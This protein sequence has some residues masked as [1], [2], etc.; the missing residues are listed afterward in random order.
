M[1]GPAGIVPGK[2]SLLER[3]LFGNRRAVLLICALLTVVLGLSARGITLNAAFD[4][5]IPLRHPFIQNFLR[6]QGDLRAGGNSLKI[7]V[8]TTGSILDP[9]YLNTLRAINDD[10]FLM[11]GIDRPYMQSLW[12]PSVRWLAVTEQGFAGGP[13]MPDH[14]DGSAAATAGLRANIM[15]SGEVGQLV[16]PDFKSSMLLVPLL[17]RDATTGAMLDYG[18]LSRRLDAMRLKYSSATIGIHIVGF[19][20]VMGDLIG[21]LHQILW[22]FAL[23]VVIATAAVYWFTR[24]LR[25]TAVVVACSLVA[26]IWQIG[27]LPLLGF[28]FDPYSILVPFLIFAI[29]MSH[30][31]Q[32]MN[33]VMQDIGRGLPS[34]QAARMTFRRLFV[35]GLTAL[36]CDAVGFAVLLVI[37]IQAIHSLALIASLGVAILVIT[38]LILLP[39]LLSYV[40]VDRRAAARAVRA[41]AAVPA[42]WRFLQSFTRPR[43]AAGILGVACVVAAASWW[44][45]AGLEVGDLEPGAPELRRSSVYNQDDAYLTRH[46]GATSDQLIVMVT[47]PPGACADYA[48]LAA[49]DRLEWELQ[50]L[51]GVESTASGASLA[52]HLIPALNE[53][54]LKWAE[55][56][57]NAGTLHYLVPIAPR[58]VFNHACDLTP[59]TIN[60]ADHKADTLQRVVGQVQRYAAELS[61]HDVHFLLAG[62][63]GGIEAAT[64]AVVA[65]SSRTMLLYVY[66]AVV[67]LSLITF[68]SWRGV[69][70]AVIP[71]VL[72]SLAANALMVILGIGLKVATL[73]VTALGVGIGV[74]YALYTLS[75]TLAAMRA[76]ASLAEAYLGALQFTGRVVMLTGFTLAAAVM[77]WA[78]S[79]IKFQADMGVLLSFMFLVNM[80]GALVL[81]PALA[82]FLLRPSR[83]AAVASRGEDSGAAPMLAMSA[84]VDSPWH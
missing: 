6:H 60:L 68:R 34:L 26:V 75:V 82:C 53:G 2:G 62:G 30:G 10:I 78:F 20:E 46:Y 80:L 77:T 65:Q 35:A 64:N 84:P 79:P 33:G 74:D 76:G 49:I 56:L 23:S 69:L 15:R 22:F 40:G 44:I 13:V 41:D 58:E 12:T 81:L 57:P 67:L 11:P 37:G 73:P 16:A 1:M 71:L 50:A 25:S 42:V 47:S 51:P 17:E 4:S 7:V 5:R 38:N 19:A 28:G 59:L 14:Y 66:A 18:A 27:L 31:A 61:D 36:I 63:N 43:R 48:T 29:G 72:T 24:C 83:A 52:R 70:V 32:K 8:S 45:G 3:M 55:V 9:A 39:I 21:G 54:N